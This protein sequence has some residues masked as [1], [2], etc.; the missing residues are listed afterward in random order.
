[1]IFPVERT[2][3]ITIALGVDFILDLNFTRIS[4]LYFMIFIYMN[5]I[6]N[7]KV[8]YKLKQCCKS[9]EFNN[10]KEN[11]DDPDF[12]FRLSSTFKK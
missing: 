10:R 7:R 2:S 8:Y 3:W 11:N 9:N 5:V 6:D 12:T 4:E 1:M